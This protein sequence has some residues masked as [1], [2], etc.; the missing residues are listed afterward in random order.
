MKF[1]ILFLATADTTQEISNLKFI[2]SK[3]ATEM[4]HFRFVRQ[5]FQLQF[6]IVST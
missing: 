6:E 2:Y 3:M 1:I 4:T 5:E